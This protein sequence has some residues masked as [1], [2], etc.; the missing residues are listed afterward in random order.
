MLFS[1]LRLFVGFVIFLFCCCVGV[2][3]FVLWDAVSTV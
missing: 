1:F 2:V 3:D